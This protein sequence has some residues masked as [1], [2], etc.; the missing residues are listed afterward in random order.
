MTDRPSS[1]P[2]IVGNEILL[3]TSE[4]GLPVK[5]LITGCFEAT[6]SCVMVIRFIEPPIFNDTSECIL[7]LLDRCFSTQAREDLELDPWTP[8]LEQKY[9]DFVREGDAEEFFDYWEA[10][11]QSDR[12]WSAYYVPNHS[13]WSPVKWE[14]YIQWQAHDM[15]EDEKKSYQ[16]M[17]VLQ[18]AMV[19]K[20][21]GEV[22]LDLPTAAAV[23]DA[24]QNPSEDAKST[25]SGHTTDEPTVYS[26]PGLLLQY[27]RGF[28]LTDLHEHLPREHWQSTIDCSL[29]IIRQI[30]ECG[31]LNCDVNTRNFIIN[32]V[33]Y[34]PMMIDFGITK[35]RDDADNDKEWEQ[36]QAWNDGEDQ[37]AMT[38]RGRLRELT[39]SSITYKP[40][41][42]HWRFC[43]RYKDPEGEREGGTEDEEEYVK[44]HRDFVFDDSLWIPSKK[45]A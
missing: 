32:P 3:K 5:A 34:K 21:L 23:D 43:Y 2:Y 33:T 35:F 37:I 7:K 22:F 41:E 40:T 20:M 36:M 31:V 14:A 24:E 18:G 26:F 30:Q 44:K 42:K 8:A 1:C 38:M 25:G 6:L 39:G 17:A 12:D 29:A 27:V 28:A 16:L 9:E 15:Y 13:K 19:P 45:K 4:E 10:E 11:K